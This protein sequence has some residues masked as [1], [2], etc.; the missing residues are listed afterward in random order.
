MLSDIIGPTL[1]P[2]RPELRAVAISSLTG[3]LTLD[4]RSGGLGNEL[5]RELLLAVRDWAD[6]VLVGARTFIAENYAGT[7][8]SQMAIISRTLQL[9]DRPPSDALILTPRSS[10]AHAPSNL[11]PAEL[12]PADSPQEMIEALHARGL[13]RIACEG[14]PG[15]FN[16]MFA[17]DL[18]DVLHLTVAPLISG[19]VDKHLVHDVN[20]WLTL[21]HHS[22]T[23][24]GTLFLRY[25]RGP[26][27]L[28]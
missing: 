3:S 7:R 2:G 26:E 10:L 20:R 4:G 25:R 14:G 24:D 15:V 9:G 23:D 19:P 1:P 18:V 6:V 27:G 11:S 28:R 12:I 5:D 8:A 22:A 21:E 13:R 16:M 17:A